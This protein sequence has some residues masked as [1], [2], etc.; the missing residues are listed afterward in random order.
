MYDEEAG[1]HQQTIIE[2]PV[3]KY[4]GEPLQHQLQHFVDL[5]E[6]RADAAAELDSLLAPHAVIDQVEAAARA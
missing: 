6:G 2:I 3:V 4:P 5:V 1:Y